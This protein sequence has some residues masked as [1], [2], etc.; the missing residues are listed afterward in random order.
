MLN[1]Y[2]IIQGK[3]PIDSYIVES[4]KFNTIEISVILCVT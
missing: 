1:Y 3:W 4:M 2:T